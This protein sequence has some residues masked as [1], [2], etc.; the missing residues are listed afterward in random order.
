MAAAGRICKV[1]LIHSLIKE[2]NAE[3]NKSVNLYKI[4]YLGIRQVC[5]SAV[6]LNRSIVRI[7]GKLSEIPVL[8]CDF[9]LSK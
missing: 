7:N 3:L 1:S 5:I 8:L 6:I 4:N 2:G 9:Q